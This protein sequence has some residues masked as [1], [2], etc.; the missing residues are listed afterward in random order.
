MTYRTG[1]ASLTVSLVL[2][3]AACGSVSL[4]PDGGGN[5]AASGGAGRGSGSAGTSGAAGSGSGVAGTTGAAGSGVAG[6]SG[7]AGGGAGGATGS[8]GR[9]AGG[10]TGAAGSGAAGTGAGGLGACTQH[11]CG[12]PPPYAQP[13]CPT[14]TI[15]GPMCTRGTDGMCAWHPPYCSVQCQPL[16]CPAI[17]CPYGMAKD[18]NGCPTC[19]CNP[20]PAGTHQVACPKILCALDC[21]DGFVHGANGCTVCQCRAPAACAP[22]GVLCV[23]CP[24]GYRT[25]P[26]GCRSCACEDPPAGCAVDSAGAGGV[27][28]TL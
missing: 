11:E 7:S 25:G 26:N 5:D 1:L 17:D 9:G 10:T 8:A 21:V 2:V 15:I 18:A 20:C 4:G 14:G 12:G 13:Y 27:G 28:G 24:F 3:A 22:G 23:R 6:V 19:Q 16:A